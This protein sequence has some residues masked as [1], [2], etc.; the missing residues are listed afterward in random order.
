MSHFTVL[1]V[2]KEGES[3]E[4]LLAPFQENNMG[5]CPREFMEFENCEEEYKDE[6]E[7]EGLSKAYYSRLRIN[8][9]QFESLLNTGFVKIDAYEQMPFDDGKYAQAMLVNVW[10]EEHKESL[11]GIISSAEFEEIERDGRKVK[12]YKLEVYSAPEVKLEEYPFK[13][14]Y[15]TYQEFLE[16]YHGL[17]KD[18]EMDA[19][20]YWSNPNSKWDW[21]LMGGRWTGY[22]KPK[23]KA[24]GDVGEPG[25]MTERP[26]NGYV[27][28]IM[29]KNVDF[30]GMKVDSLKKAETNWDEFQKD[31]Q[32]PNKKNHARFMWNAKED[33]TKEEFIKERTA[34]DG[35]QP[36]AFI[37]KNGEWVEKGEMGWWGMVHDEDADA[38]EDAFEKFVKTL[39]PDDILTI[40]DC[41]I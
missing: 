35:W 2:H 33:I 8:K 40:W 14:K 23:A 21:Y 13:K 17:S 16:D 28:Q 41:H 10:G 36:F 7:K 32:D 11:T 18:E 30:E 38:H 6:Y 15:A 1:T 20:G 19:Y 26:T 25:L 9:E 29:V 31:L 4:E 5:D 22:F 39:E 27:D 24:I 12:V 3:P 37:D 34:G